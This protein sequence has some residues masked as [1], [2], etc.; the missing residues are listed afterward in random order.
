MDEWD[1]GWYPGMGYY[2]LGADTP[3]SPAPGPF[4]V[5]ISKDAEKALKKLDKNVQKAMQ[6]KIEQ[7]KAYPEVS[8]VKRMW[9]KAYG[10]ERLKF[11]DYRME[12]SVNMKEH[13]IVIEKIGHRDTMYDEYH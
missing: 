8:G 1:S 6:D 10:R 7:L 9:G 12:F 2:Y 3:A 5:E 13:K 4:N 11:W